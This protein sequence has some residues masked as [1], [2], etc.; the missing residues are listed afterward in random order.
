MKPD[1]DSLLEKTEKSFFPLLLQ[2]FK[3]LA[4]VAAHAAQIERLATLSFQDM[5]AG[6]AHHFGAMRTFESDFSVRMAGTME[7]AVFLNGLGRWCLA[8]DFRNGDFGVNGFHIQ[9]HFTETQLLART[10]PGFLHRFAVEKRAVGGIAITK[11]NPVMGQGQ[12]AVQRR[13][14]VMVQVLFTVGVAAHVVDPH[15][16]FKSLD[17]ES[18]GLDKQSGHK[19]S[20]LSALV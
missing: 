5:D 12:F 3:A 4:F 10:Q 15:L 2:D 16:Q 17:A 11:I 9:F 8:V 18:C 1:L 13:D 20:E 7:F 6:V 14:G 19:T